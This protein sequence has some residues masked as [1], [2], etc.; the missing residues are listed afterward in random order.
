LHNVILGGFK[1]STLVKTPTDWI[2]IESISVGDYVE[3]LNC[4]ELAH[5]KITH[6]RVICEKAISIILDGESIIASREQKFYLASGIWQKAKSLKP[7]DVL[8]SHDKGFITIQDVYEIKQEIELY[9]ITVENVHTYLVTQ[10]GILV[11]NVAPVVIGLS[12]LFGSGTIEFVGASIFW[13][14][15]G[16][17]GI[18]FFK[19]KNRNLEDFKI[20]EYSV[21]FGSGAPDPDKDE[22]KNKS[23]VKVCEKSAKHIFRNKSG[24]LEDTSANRNLL[25][26]VASNFK[27]YLGIDQYGNQWFA[28]TLSNGRQIWASVRNNFI[29]N[30]GINSEL[31]TFNPQTGLSKPL[32]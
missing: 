3:S 22:K 15:L 31:K 2:N 12:W 16:F 25:I 8:F 29:R 18:K 14:A 9:E 1:N 5:N 23:K 13:G 10:H 30:G 19:N 11:H 32:G 20:G 27:N 7:G 6:K 28:K 24:H 17:L 4:E 21:K 26:R